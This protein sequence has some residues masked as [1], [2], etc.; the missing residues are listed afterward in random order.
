MQCCTLRIED[1]KQWRSG[2]RNPA[3]RVALNHVLLLS[4]SWMEVLDVL[5]ANTELMNFHCSLLKPLGGECR[6]MRAADKRAI[7]GTTSQR[8]PS[9]AELYIRGLTDV[10]PLADVEL[11]DREVDEEMEWFVS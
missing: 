2:M 9:P 11:T 5:R 1:L 8:G 7:F 10:N 4:G 6:R 3:P